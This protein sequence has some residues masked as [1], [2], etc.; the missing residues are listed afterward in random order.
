MQTELYHLE[1]KL[2]SYIL[3]KLAH[4][5]VYKITLWCLQEERSINCNYEQIL[6]CWSRCLVEVSQRAWLD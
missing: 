6:G 4:F 3:F 5:G 1:K 2:V